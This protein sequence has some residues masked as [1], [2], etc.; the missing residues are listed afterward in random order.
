M[1]PRRRKLPPPR[2]MTKILRRVMA[3]RNRRRRPLTASYGKAGKS[4]R[5]KSNRAVCSRRGR[6]P[7]RRDVFFPISS[8]SEKPLPFT[9][10]K[11]REGTWNYT[12]CEAD[13]IRVHE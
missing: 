11:G 10:K 13:L 8:V 6:R 1:T 12:D 5:W 4:F 3:S 7:V 9:K 2:K